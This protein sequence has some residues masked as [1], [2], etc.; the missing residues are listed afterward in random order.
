[1]S[2]N[3][4]ALVVSEWKVPQCIEMLYEYG[5]YN[6]QRVQAMDDGQFLLY[7]WYED[8]EFLS[9]YMMEINQ[10]IMAATAH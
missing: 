1:M 10:R 3:P 9:L 7:I 5:I 6:I 2:A 4:I 8:Q